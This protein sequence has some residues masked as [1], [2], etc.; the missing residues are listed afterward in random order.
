MD[1][2]TKYGE[3]L[4][5]FKKQLFFMPLATKTR[6]VEKLQ[7]MDI[8]PSG[9][10]LHFFRIVHNLEDYSE[11]IPESEYKKYTEQFKEIK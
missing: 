3:S 1:E 4:K 8:I 6:F 5:G 10:T 7:K 2:W 9:D 11:V